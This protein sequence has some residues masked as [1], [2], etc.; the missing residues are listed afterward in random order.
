MNSAD[1]RILVKFAS[2][3]VR[4]MDLSLPSS[5][6]DPLNYEEIF[7]DTSKKNEGEEED[8]EKFEVKKTKKPDFIFIEIDLNDLVRKKVGVDFMLP[9]IMNLSPST[10]TSDKK[11]FGVKFSELMYDEESGA[12]VREL[13]GYPPP[14]GEMKKMRNCIRHD[15]TRPSMDL[16]LK[17]FFW[18]NSTKMMGFIS[19]EQ[20]QAL[21]EMYR[22]ETTTVVEKKADNAAVVN[23]RTYLTYL[24]KAHCYSTKC[25]FSSVLTNT[26]IKR[27]K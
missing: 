23:N 11:L 3:L 17:P 19:A 4:G 18:R 13:F 12:I 6:N 24:C 8:E 26:Q 10:F 21:E 15:D 2:A 1:K 7:P 27:L 22:G 25:K 20:D 5:E 14:E 9:T 16:I